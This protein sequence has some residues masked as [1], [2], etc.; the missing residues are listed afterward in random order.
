MAL[1]V[2]TQAHNRHMFISYYTAALAVSH[3]AD[4][5]LGMII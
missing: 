4:L 1:Q 5:T 2:M 3:T